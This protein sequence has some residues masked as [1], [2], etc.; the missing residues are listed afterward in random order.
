MSPSLLEITRIAKVR[1]ALS[2]WEQGFHQSLLLNGR[3]P[4][5]KQRDAMLRLAQKTGVAGCR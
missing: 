1:G 2:E 3:A 4:T 5:T